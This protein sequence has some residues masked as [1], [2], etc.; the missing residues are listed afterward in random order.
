MAVL[1]SSRPEEL[2]RWSDADEAMRS[3]QLCE[4]LVEARGSMALEL[5]VAISQRKFSL[6]GEIETVLGGID[7]GEVRQIL[8][9]VLRRR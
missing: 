8:E 3:R 4:F 7:S 2:R 5:A 1:R 6:I 9:L